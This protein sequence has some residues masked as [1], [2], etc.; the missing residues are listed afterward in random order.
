MPT[1]S[2]RTIEA[3]THSSA[4]KVQTRLGLNRLV[5]VHVDSHI[6]RLQRASVSR[7]YM[8]SPSLDGVTLATISFAFSDWKE[9]KPSERLLLPSYL[10][11]FDTTAVSSHAQFRSHALSPPR[12]LRHV[13]F[14][15][16]VLAFKVSTL[17]DGCATRSWQ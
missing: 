7:L 15:C 4:R 12:F 6:G 5:R 14:L 11:R 13:S 9:R 1:C 2:A 16:H 3:S 10:L 17:T 8:R